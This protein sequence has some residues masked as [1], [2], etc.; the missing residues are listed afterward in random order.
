[1][2]KIEELSASLRAYRPTDTDE[3]AYQSR[4]LTLCE[5]PH[6]PFSRLHFEPGHF[7]ASAF[8][9]SPDRRAL[10]LIFHGKLSRWLQPGG[11]VDA[12]DASIL[13]SARREVSEEVGLHDL[14]LEHDGIFDLDIHLIPARKTEPAHEHFD[15]RFLF[16]AKDLHF[17]VGSDAKAARWVDLEEVREE[18]ADRSVMRA[19]EKLKRSSR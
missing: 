19:V 3:A 18:I 2:G 11:H 9:L 8:V 10:L 17:E 15:V 4:M 5:P 6:E 13:A 12:I 16:R 14:P 1:M 7:T